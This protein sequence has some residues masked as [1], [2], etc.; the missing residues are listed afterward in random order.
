MP[1]FRVKVRVSGSVSASDTVSKLNDRV[2]VASTVAV[3]VMSSMTGI[4]VASGTM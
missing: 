2:P 1:S 3:P 4:L